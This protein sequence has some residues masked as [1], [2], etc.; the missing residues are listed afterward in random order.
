MS[1]ILSNISPSF[2]KFYVALAT[3][4]NKPFTEVDI[5]VWWSELKDEKEENLIKTYRHF[6][7]SGNQTIETGKP[8]KF[9]TI[10]EFKE[11]IRGIKK[12]EDEKNKSSQKKLTKENEFNHNAKNNLNKLINSFKNG[13]EIHKSIIDYETVTTENDR[14]F[15]IN[16]DNM[17]RSFCKIEK[18]N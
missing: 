17:G 3:A 7:N 8:L 12:R 15:K 5:S 4:F 16:T 2:K 18:I 10:P 1:Q 6:M 9:P 14:R 13:H 11:I